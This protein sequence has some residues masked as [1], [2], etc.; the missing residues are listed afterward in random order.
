MYETT[1]EPEGGQEVILID[2]TQMVF[3]EIKADTTVAPVEEEGEQAM[4]E[5]EDKA[6]PQ[7]SLQPPATAII[8]TSQSEVSREQGAGSREQC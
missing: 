2:N 8:H 1:V 3:K 6:D 5:K 7:E 4:K